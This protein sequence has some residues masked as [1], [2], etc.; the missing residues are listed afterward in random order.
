MRKKEQR[1]YGNH[2]LLSL[3]LL[4]DVREDTWEGQVNICNPRERT[5]SRTSGVETIRVYFALG[6]PRQLAREEDIGGFSLDVPLAGSRVLFWIRARHRVQVQHG[7]ERVQLARHGDHT[8]SVVLS[9]SGEQFGREQLRQKEWPNVRS[10]HLAFEPVNS[11]V[12]LHHGGGS[13]VD[14]HLLRW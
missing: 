9:A 14:Q 7:P 2:I 11:Q 1:T 8:R 10:R 6:A 12:E 4:Q 3:L 5:A 13:I